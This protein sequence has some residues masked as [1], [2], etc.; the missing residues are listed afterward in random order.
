[1]DLASIGQTVADTHRG[2]KWI[3][4]NEVAAGTTERVATLFDHGAS[5]VMVVAASEGVGELPEPSRIHYTRS[6]ASTIMDGVRAFSQ[7]VEHPSP[8]LVAAVES[9]D[10]SHEAMVL[11]QG[12]ARSSVLADRP[13]YGAR[14]EA[15][16][17]LEDKMIADD[18]WDE[19]A[20]ARA[21]SVLVPP[22]MA[23]SAA[24]DFA[25]TLGTVWV[26]DNREGWHGGG[27]YV[28]WVR[29]PSDAE[30]ATTWFSEHC[31]RL[32]V[33]PFLDGIPC[34]IHGFATDDGVAV[35]LPMELF[36]LRIVGQSA[37][38]YARGANYWTP[39]ANLTDEMRHAARAVGQVLRRRYGYR[40]GFGI[41]G[42]ATSDGFRPTELNPRL[43][44]GHSIQALAAD[45]PLVDMEPL[46]IAGDLTVR[47]AELEDLIVPSVTGRRRGG[48]LF[49]VPGD[50]GHEETGFRFTDDGVDAVPIDVGDSAERDGELLMGPAGFGSVVI[51]RFDPD[52]TP[53]GPSL[54]PRAPLL[55]ALARDLWGV[56]LPD[57]EAAPDVAR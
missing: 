29:T 28:R 4:V 5:G 39:P 8:A 27:S 54:A 48:M 21:R 45:V 42:V 1:M 44:I 13:V 3:V 40:G 24:P 31:D 16:T 7:S 36:I 17:A 57:T 32:R 38:F 53:I 9:F 6:R 22:A 15:W 11:G 52:R 37:F 55:M 30:A 51:A 46:V 33:M 49:A 12:L 47:A 43:T 35:L 20:I 14:R 26:G 34:S 50:H 19:A 10:P 56:D 25:S 41:D 18:L 2:R 23:A